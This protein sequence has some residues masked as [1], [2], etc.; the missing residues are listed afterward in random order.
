MTKIESVPSIEK[1]IS[2]FSCDWFR[3]NEF[4]WLLSSWRIYY[5]WKRWFHQYLFLYR[6]L[7]CVIRLKSISYWEKQY[8][9]GFENQ[10]YATGEYFIVN[11]YHNRGY[12]KLKKSTSYL[13]NLI[14]IFQHKKIMADSQAIYYERMGSITKIY[15]QY[16][17]QDLFP[18]STTLHQ[19]FILLR[20]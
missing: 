2:R 18:I 5:V 17:R 16:R 4:T 9:K 19:A 10:K 7:L 14:F 20:Q 12:L 6:H 13:A 11:M 3:A 1:V 8:F 15:K